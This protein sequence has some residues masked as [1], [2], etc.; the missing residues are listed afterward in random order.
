MNFNPFNI[1][2][3]IKQIGYPVV[4]IQFFRPNSLQS[5]KCEIFEQHESG[6][7]CWVVCIGC[8]QRDKYTTTP[9]NGQFARKN[10]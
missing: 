10:I 8:G 4:K 2:T 6:Y 5:Y 1:P 9:A 3:E 7:N